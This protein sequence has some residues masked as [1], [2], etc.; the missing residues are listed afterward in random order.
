MGVGNKI[1]NKYKAIPDPVKA[2]IWFTICN[3][4]QK[5]IALI[6][7]PIFT[8]IMTTDQYGQYSVYQS[9]YSIVAIFATLNLYAGVYN[10]GLLKWPNDRHRYTSTLQ[11]LSTTLTIALFVIYIC[12]MPFWN[13]L[14]SMNSVFMFAMFAE[15][16]FAPAYNFWAAEQRFEYKYRKLVL[17]TLVLALASPILGI[18]AV[19]ATEYKAE[20]RVLAFVFVQVCVG[21]IFYIYNMAKGKQFYS[22][23]YWKFALAFTLPLIPHY[24]SQVVLG[25]ADRIMIQRMVGYSE[26]ALYSVAYTISMMFN[27]VTTAINNSF[28]PYT[29][30]SIKDKKYDALSGNASFLVTCVAVGCVL[31]TAFGPEIIRI[32]A[33]P[34]YYDAYRVVPPVAI[35]LLFIFMSSL[36]A[37]VEFYYEETKFIMVASSI[38]AVTNVI[39]NYLGI[40]WFGYVAA[41][42]TT[43]I[44]YILLALAHFVAHKRILKK[45]AEES[46]ASETNIYN[47]K[48]LLMI[49]VVSVAAMLGI[50]LIYEQMI[51]RY[52]VIATIL[53]IAFIKKKIIMEKFKEIRKK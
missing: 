15:L 47:S 11:G 5:G 36:F 20:A 26:A 33:S 48:Y 37:N 6:T 28:I 4:L 21:L 50:L 14:L 34:E 27:I 52:V 43:L 12:A 51:L 53:V 17:V 2:S 49:S 35:S 45:R 25:Q 41:A 46:Q 24:L 7:T 18:I 23:G 29:Y 40:K 8:R 31:A 38:A 1:A 30:K 39:L 32:F 22:K 19:Q 42:Y 44:C 9:W 13:N 16:L 3:V 10:N